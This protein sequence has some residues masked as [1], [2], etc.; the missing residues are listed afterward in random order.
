MSEGP[1]E[2]G[3]AAGPPETAYVPSFPAIRK[4]DAY[5]A[6]GE[7]L[8]CGALFVGM[9]LLV[10]AA[11]VTE[12]FGVRRNPIDLVALFGVCLLGV[13]TRAVKEGERKPAWPLSLAIAAG[14]T[15]AIGGGVYLYVSQLPGGLPWAQKLSLVAMLWVALL[16]ASIAA[17]DRA[18]I[19]LE[20]GEKLWPKKLVPYIK[21]LAHGVTSAVCVIGCILAVHLVRKESGTIEA[22]EWLPRTYVFVIVPYMFAAMAVRFLA[23]AVTIATGTSAPTEDRLPT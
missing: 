17:H 12:V 6:K 13:R 4:L 10:F 18:H 9:S 22:N 19:A 1:G 14:L 20:F 21:A 11:V 15:V 7:R 8:L 2:G 23:Q 3:A 16:G 5:W